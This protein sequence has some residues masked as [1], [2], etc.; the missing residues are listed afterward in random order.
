MPALCG[1]RPRG[2]S[3]G[4]DHHAYRVAPTR[5]SSDVLESRFLFLATWAPRVAYDESLHRRCLWEARAVHGSART[6]SRPRSG[7]RVPGAQ[8]LKTR[9]VQGA[10]HR[11]RCYQEGGCGVWRGAFRAG[12]VGGPAVLLWQVERL[13]AEEVVLAE[14]CHPCRDQLSMGIT[15]V[16]DSSERESM[17]VLTYLRIVP[18]AQKRQRSL[19]ETNLQAAL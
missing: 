11:P 19:S 9:R 4:S 13:L 8:R 1:N 17:T 18:L 14:K 5:E 7:R 6:E 3:I 16:A 10:H 12:R 2:E 15:L